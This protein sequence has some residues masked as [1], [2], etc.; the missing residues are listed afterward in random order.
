M[1]IDW[2][3][4]HVEASASP[5]V[6]DPRR[7]LRICLGCFAV[8]LLAIV[9]RAV[10]LEVSEGAAFRA[11]TLRPVEREVPLPA[12][13]GRIL[14]RDGTVLARDEHVAALAVEYRRLQQP[15]D[16]QWLRVQVRARLS[17]T[18]RN[19]ARRVAEERTKVLAERD[20]ATRRMAALC[21]LS[22]EE[23]TARVKTIQARVE[24]IAEAAN[25]RRQAA[26]EEN[27]ARADES[28]PARFRRWLLE[29]P[30]PLKIIVAEELRPHVVFENL[31]PEAA[32][33]IERHADRYPGAKVLRLVR[34]SYP[35]GSL[36]AHLLGHLGRSEDSDAGELVGRMGVEKQCD[37]VLQGRPG[38]AVER[39]DRRGRVASTAVRREPRA[40]R[41]VRLTI[42]CALQQTAEALL[43]PHRGAI[44][45]LDA[46]DGAVLA[47]ASAPSFSPNVFAQGHA[48]AV[49]RL[50]DDPA[51]PLFDRVC[52]MAI[53]PGSTF[54]TL[55]AIALLESKI[56]E[57]E[58]PFFCQGYLH[59]P[60]RL[61]CET[62]V[63]Q[64]VGHGEITLSDA[65]AESC[66]VY[67]FH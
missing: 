15:A 55:T 33:E 34:R 13:R 35:N 30:P 49:R 2:R 56:V 53:P 61:R 14:A 51:A 46:A 59:E 67:F 16:E 19:D 32:A 9:V 20:A 17:K 60:D 1:P 23:W 31:S 65:L 6:V 62:F 44:V 39:L 43:P 45:A 36:A 3:Q 54:K 63:R 38:L 42:D 26:D 21:G 27:A 47:A 4:F 64:G 8:A 66:N 57:P 28:W 10:Q 52:R 11:D 41:D 18:E 50:L 37:S 40:G 58:T 22:T 12:P 5:A 7:R 24:R 48:D 25:R 29:E